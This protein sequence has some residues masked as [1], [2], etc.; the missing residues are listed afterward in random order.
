MVSDFNVDFIV[1]IIR[2]ACG[3]GGG[4]VKSKI[5]PVE[6][7]KVKSFFFSKM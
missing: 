1:S 4:Y 5:K 7:G 6:L 3:G 2:D